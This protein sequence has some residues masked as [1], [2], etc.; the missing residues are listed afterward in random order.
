MI[1]NVL[2]Y[3]VYMENTFGYLFNMNGQP[4]LGILHAS[5]LKRSTF[6][7]LGGPICVNMNEVRKATVN[8]FEEYRVCVP[9][10][11]S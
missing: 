1:T 11:F 3:A 2:F 7:W 4:Y 5:V 6:N 8:D 10:D 9:P